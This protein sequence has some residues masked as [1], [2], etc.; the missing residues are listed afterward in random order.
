[1][2]A[3][4]PAT[5]VTNPV[6]STV[7]MLA[8]DV[9]QT[10]LGVELLNWMVLLTHTTPAVELPVGWAPATQLDVDPVKAKLVNV[11]LLPLLVPSFNVVKPVLV[12][13]AVPWLKL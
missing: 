6:L 1:M 13:P 12:P 8:S 10:P 4:P 9:D 11:P 2:V 3:E 7:A 5:P